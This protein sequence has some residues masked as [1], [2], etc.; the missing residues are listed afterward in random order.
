MGDLAR[1]AGGGQGPA[2]GNHRF[3]I[4]NGRA[5]MNWQNW[6][7]DQ[8]QRLRDGPLP[9]ALHPDQPD[10]MAELGIKAGDM[11]EVYNDVGAT[12]ALAYPEPTAKRT[13][14]S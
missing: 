6:F 9:R 13:R 3:F 11:V 4:N 12:Q 1:L 7:L 8:R 14:P 10:D 2:A 5:N